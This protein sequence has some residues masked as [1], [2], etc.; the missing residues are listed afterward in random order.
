MAPLVLL[1]KIKRK[2]RLWVTAGAKRLGQ[3]KRESNPALYF[4]WSG[5]AC[6]NTSELSDWG[7][8]FAPVKK[9]YSEHKTCCK[10][11]ALCSEGQLY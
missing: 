4:I 11:A 3:I 2:V 7:K 1:K 5:L 9:K 8:A 6:Q 10:A